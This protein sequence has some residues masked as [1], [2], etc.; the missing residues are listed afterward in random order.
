[1]KLLD[2]LT[3]SKKGRG[4]HGTNTRADVV[5]N[6]DISNIVISRTLTAWIHAALSRLL[7][8]LHSL[9]TDGRVQASFWGA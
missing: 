1:V 2:P 3:E 7:N 5:Q 6:V 8:A 4:E 9:R